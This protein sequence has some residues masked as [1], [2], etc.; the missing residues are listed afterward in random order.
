MHS[1]SNVDGSLLTRKDAVWRRRDGGNLKSRCPGG[2]GVGSG[3]LICP[4]PTTFRRFVTGL[5]RSLG[6]SMDR[7]SEFC[8]RRS[9][10]LPAN[11]K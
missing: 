1:V 4:D 6:L 11:P 9:S 3:G 5:R 7:A 8:S 2:E 10:Q